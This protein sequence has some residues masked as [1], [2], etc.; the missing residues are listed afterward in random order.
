MI[1]LDRQIHFFMSAAYTKGD[2]LIHVFSGIV[3]E[4]QK[5]PPDGKSDPVEHIQI[6]L[7]SSNKS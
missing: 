2:K 3:F 5:T 1:R 4:G 6:L 7:G